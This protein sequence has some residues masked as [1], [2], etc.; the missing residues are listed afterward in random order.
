MIRTFNLKF[1]WI[2]KGKPRSWAPIKL[3]SRG[4]INPII[5]TWNAKCY[6]ISKIILHSNCFILTHLILSAVFVKKFSIPFIHRQVA[7]HVF[8]NYY[9][10]LAFVNVGED[11][12]RFSYDLNF[13]PTKKI[14]RNMAQWINQIIRIYI[15]GLDNFLV[16]SLPM[17]YKPIA[18]YSMLCILIS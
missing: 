13:V 7:I 9:S 3:S 14:R 1:V 16:N 17:N 18:D 5:P 15:Y 4:D 10:I 12:K 2:C 6:H 8:E 11:R